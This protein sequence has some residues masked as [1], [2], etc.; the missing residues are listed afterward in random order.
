ML[1]PILISL[2]LLAVLFLPKLLRNVLPKTNSFGEMARGF[3]RHEKILSD[4]GIYLTDGNNQKFNLTSLQGSGLSF[5]LAI[6]PAQISVRFLW[7]S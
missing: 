2:T 3:E 4:E 6:L 5:F 1:R 7:R